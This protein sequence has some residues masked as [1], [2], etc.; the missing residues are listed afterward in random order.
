[1]LGVLC[2]LLAAGGIAASGSGSGTYERLR[3]VAAPAK[4]AKLD[5]H[6]ESMRAGRVRVE[7][8]AAQPGDARALVTARGGRVESSYGRLVEAIVPAASLEALARSRSGT[9]RLTILS[10]TGSPEFSTPR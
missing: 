4:V 3:P 2:G 6:L 1:M 9:P 8:V 10:A 7:L 5:S